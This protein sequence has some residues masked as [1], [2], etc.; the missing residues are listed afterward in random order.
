VTND[1]GAARGMAAVRGFGSDNHSG[2]HPEVLEAIAAANVGHAFAYGEDLW[3]A[4]AIDVLQGHFGQDAQVAFTFNGTGTNIIALSALCRPWESVICA[5]TAHIN[6][7]ECAAPEHIANVKL[8]PVATADGKLTPD[9]VRAHLTGFGFEHHA[10]PR[11]VSV[12]NVA[13]LG[14]VYSPFELRALADLAHA[15]DMALHVDGARIANA[16]AGLGVPLSAL[17]GEAGVDALSL[18]GTKNGMLAGEAVV[19]FGEARSSDLPYIRKQS[20]QLASK[21]R[22]VA[23]Q[24]LAMFDGDLWLR[25][26]SHANAMAAR[27]AAGAQG[28]G[29]EITQPVQANEVFALLPPEATPRLQE[30]FKFY[31]WDESRNEVRWVASWDTTEDDVDELVQALSAI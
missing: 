1:S 18:G 15:H 31:V 22:F 20:A 7:D 27:L 23:A 26:A 28:A 21:M 4:R 12:S 10:Q 30:R 14:T 25:C 3:T 5:Q 24:F 17:A 6:V 11:V 29:I 19:L 16:A 2:V 9:L 13:E 8:V